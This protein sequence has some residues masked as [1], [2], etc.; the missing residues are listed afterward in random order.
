MNTDEG[1]ETVTWIATWNSNVGAEMY[2]IVI[3][4]LMGNERWCLDGV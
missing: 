1:I 4:G 2:C 3:E